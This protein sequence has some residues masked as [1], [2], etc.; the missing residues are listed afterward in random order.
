MVYQYRE[1][2]A[3]LDL[4]NIEKQV[5]KARKVVA[6]TTPVEKGRFL[7]ISGA[8]KPGFTDGRAGNE[9]LR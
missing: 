1:K 7:K 5:E 8:A 2:R 3:R 6:G 4:R 9:P